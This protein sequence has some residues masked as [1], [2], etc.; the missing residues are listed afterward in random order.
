[1]KIELIDLKKRY[2]DEREELLSC[3]DRVLKNGSLVLTDEVQNFEKNITDFTNSKFCLGLNS[4]TDALMMAL[5]SLNIGRGDEVIT[6][7]IS[8]IAS[9]GAIVHVGAKPV[10][11]DVN[12][13]K[14]GE[15]FLDVIIFTT[16][17]LIKVLCN[18]H[19]FPLISQP[20]A[21]SPILV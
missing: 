9:V 16:S 1:M 2:K 7:P 8:F 6:T 17:P 21:A 15:A 4:G 12:Q 11:V 5:W 13:C 10:F 18:G 3:F 20:I 14:D 19:S